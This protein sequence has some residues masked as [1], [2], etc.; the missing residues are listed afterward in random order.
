MLPVALQ[1]SSNMLVE[2][3]LQSLISREKST[4]FAAATVGF[5][6]A[7]MEIDDGVEKTSSRH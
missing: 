6:V 2:V 3:K 5:P 7:F 1:K 4:A